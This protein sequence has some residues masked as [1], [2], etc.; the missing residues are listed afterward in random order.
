MVTRQTLVIVLLTGLLGGPSMAQTTPATVAGSATFQQDGANWT[1]TTS[2]PK[3]VINWNSFSVAQGATV[4][5]Q[6]P[7]AGSAVL[8]RVLGSQ[9]SYINGLLSS[10]GGIFLLNPNGI[11]IGRTGAI[12]AADFLASTHPIADAEFLA[13]GNLNFKGTS[14]AAIENCGKIEAIG[15]SIY[16]IASKVVNQG[17]LTASS[18]SVNLAAGTDVLLTQD[19]CLYVRPSVSASGQDVGVENTGTIDAVVARLQASGNMY[20]LAINNAGAVRATGS[21]IADGRVLLQ[22]DGGSVVSTG[23]L[24][25]KTI[26]ADGKAAGGEIQVLG[27]RVAISGR[28]DASGEAGGGFVETSGN[29]LDLDDMELSVGAG[30]TWLLDPPA[31]TI[32]PALA[33]TIVAQ[34]ESGTN[35]TQSATSLVTVAAAINAP[36][37]PASTYLRLDS[38]GAIAINANVDVGAGRL[39]LVA[40]GGLTQAAGTTVTAGRLWLSG[41]GA[42]YLNQPTN[43]FGILSCSV[44]GIG[45][46]VEIQDV[47]SLVIGTVRGVSGVSVL[48]GEVHITTPNGY[49]IANGLFPDGIVTGYHGLGNVAIGETSVQSGRY[50]I[51]ISNEL[52]Y[53]KTLAEVES[54]LG[55]PGA[56][57]ALNPATN[58]GSAVTIDFGS[59]LGDSLGYSWN[60]RVAE[61][62]NDTSANDYSFVLIRP[63]PGV[64]PLVADLETA[65]SSAKQD[66]GEFAW[67]T[68]WAAEG[69][70]L[71]HVDPYTLSLG[72]MNVGHDRYVSKLYVRSIEFVGHLPPPLFGA[73]FER[74]FDHVE[75]FPHLRP[76]RLATTPGAALLAPAL[77]E[78]TT[79]F[80]AAAQATWYL[81]AQPVDPRY[82]YQSVGSIY[83]IPR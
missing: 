69:R 8:N 13:G 51:R 14:P 29:V 10:N 4:H 31:L 17:S 32:D 52:P 74:I 70:E 26:G 40:G 76:D 2:T 45:N 41:S 36:G 5:F 80:D 30:G 61:T 23:T 20:A 49:I 42:F 83:Q 50:E 55:V 16:L 73:V 43:D 66:V 81:T 71:N 39:Y 59:L 75:D 27:D 21:V 19:H 24:A 77:S 58:V 48:G 22:A 53:S 3:T 35:V 56:L 63:E 62:F 64:P 47:S 60:F 15:G 79:F 34:L 78:V 37:T 68:G 6:Q 9:A 11:V 46:Y 72:A 25:A 44:N 1:I 28:V 33:A 7:G 18:G 54:F 65:R 12:R 82:Y 57:L 67:Q 38:G